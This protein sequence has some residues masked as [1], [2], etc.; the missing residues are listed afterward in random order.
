MNLVLLY[1]NSQLKKVTLFCIPCLENTANN[2]WEK[3][4]EKTVGN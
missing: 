3:E 2:E 4:I 1:V